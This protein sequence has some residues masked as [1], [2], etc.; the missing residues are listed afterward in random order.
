V[1]NENK[2]LKRLNR[3]GG[4]TKREP[5]DHVNGDDHV[6]KTPTNNEKKKYPAV[7]TRSGHGCNMKSKKERSK[8][9]GPNQGKPAQHPCEQPGCS[10]SWERGSDDPKAKK[11][12]DS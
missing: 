2:G 11:G 3:V 7:F 6:Q 1:K 8:A 12:G 5:W 9:Q 10:L 4:G